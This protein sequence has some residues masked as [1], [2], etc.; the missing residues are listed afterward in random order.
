MTSDRELYARGAAS[1]V[2]SWEW[3]A[4]G[5]PGA[6]V[7]RAPGVAS[8]VFPAG[9]ERG[10]YNNAFLERDLSDP[11]PAIDAMEGAYAAASVDDFAAWAHETDRP[12]VAELERRGYRL[13][14]TTRAMGMPLSDLRAFVDGVALRDAPWPEYL[15]YLT[16]F[17][18]PDGLLAGVDGSGFRIVAARLDGETVATGLAFEH[19]GDCGI[20]NVSTLERA[21]RRG[22]GTALTARLL[23]A[24]QAR[25]CVTA[26]LQSTPMAERVYATVGFRDL[27]RILEFRPG[28]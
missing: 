4:R 5:A 7:V 12:L 15:R 19:E 6:S 14:E 8:A 9:P 13:A 22:I 10:V 3:I 25:G 21:R 24:A 26:T 27:G 11:A 23:R 17:G 2:A 16:S 18:L 1:V 20:F 28:R